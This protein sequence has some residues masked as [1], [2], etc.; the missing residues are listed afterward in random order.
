MSYCPISSDGNVTVAK[1]GHF[2]PQHRRH[3]AT[4]L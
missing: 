2:P 3:W 4:H 1:R